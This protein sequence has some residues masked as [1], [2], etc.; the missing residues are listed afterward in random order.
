MAHPIDPPYLVSWNITKRCNLAC[1][2]CYLDSSELAGEDETSTDEAYRFIDEIAALAP[3]CMLV[4]TG[5]E[6]LAR[7]DIYGISRRAADCGL[8]AVIGTNGTLLTDDIVSKLMGCG[9]RGFGISVDSASS[10]FHDRFR[11]MDGAW[12]K[13]MAGMEA[14]KK[15]GA[16]FQ[17]QFSV[18]K[19]NKGEL[20]EF[21]RFALER[22]ARAVNFFFL[23]CTGR[24]QKATG[25]SVAEYETALEEITLLERCYEGRMMI[26]A[27]C[28]PQI[29]RV[30]EKK[31]T[32]SRLLKGATSGCIAGKGYLRI[33]P[34]GFVT[35][36]PYIPVNGSS[37]S[38]KE[39]T[40]RHIWENGSEFIS[41]REGTLSGRCAECEFSV[42]CGGCRARALAANGDFLSED[43]WCSHEPQK[44]QREKTAVPGWSPQALE[45]LDRIPS[46][47]RPMVKKG[48][49]G[50][51]AK[52][53]IA[54]ITPELMQQMRKKANS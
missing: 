2:H 37:L 47:I 52:R 15:A 28:A 26:R 13:T 1:G 7:P 50:Y 35:P 8:N 42:S 48:L 53:G 27:R 14:L 25:I 45:R 20:R 24:G 3:G 18:T 9:V 4:L 16:P 30:A 44:E 5:G 41:L 11:G 6:P 40:L 34:G 39:N 51:A 23:V 46:F 38:L 43:P 36:C 19:E 32:Q 33:S 49:E 54:T 21:S 31:D 12:G 22:G 10:A 29:I 17:L